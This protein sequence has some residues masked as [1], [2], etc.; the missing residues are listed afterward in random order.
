MGSPGDARAVDTSEGGRTVLADAPAP[1]D[2]QGSPAGSRSRRQAVLV[3]LGLLLGALAFAVHAGSWVGHNGDHFYY[4]ATALEYAGVPYDEAISTSADYF[5]YTKPTG[6]LDRGSLNPWVAPLMYPRD[7]LPLLALPAVKLFGVSGIWVAGVALGLGT[8]LGLVWLVWRRV[9]T[10]AAVALPVLLL[11]SVI[12]TEFMFGVYTEAPL[13]FLATATLVLLPLGGRPRGW[14]HAVGVA[15]LVPLTMASRQV[16][17]LVLGMVLGGWLWALVRTRT[18]RNPWTPFLVTVAPTAVV[19]DLVMARWAPFDPLFVLRA[20]TREDSLSGLL[21]GAAPLFYRATRGD[22]HYALDQDRVGV[23]LFALAVVGL[24]VVVRTP[25]AG[26]F[27]G[28]LGSG[29]IS[30]YLSPSAVHFRYEAPVIPVVVVLGAVGVDRLLALV[31]RVPWTVPEIAGAAETQRA[32]RQ[33]GR[34]VARRPVGQPGWP[35]AAATWSVA[36]LVVAALV[37]LHQPA[38]TQGAPSV[39]VSRAEYG[40]AWPF[41]VPSGTLTC[42]GSDYEVWFRAPDGTTYALS[43]SA[44]MRSFLTPRA[45]E[46]KAQHEQG[47]REV[48]PVLTRGMRLCGRGYQ[49]AN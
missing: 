19:A 37:A 47:W 4:T 1:P 24:V 2:A 42:A 40:R 44:M 17:V 30:A 15:A 35:T 20:F 3:G 11:G 29:L 25:L 49:A 5:D 9:G 41:T 46:L 12:C 28:A 27:A 16:P 45:L 10:A 7:L 18:L 23:A 26:V 34:A 8:L 13:I 36:V 32:E 43:G 14:G 39:Q 21:R 22:I 31:R 33:E 38:S 48:I 6:E